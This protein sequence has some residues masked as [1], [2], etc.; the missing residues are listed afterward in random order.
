M[1]CER[2]VASDVKGSGSE[3]RRLVRCALS[4]LPTGRK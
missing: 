1:L 4:A 3:P 2:L